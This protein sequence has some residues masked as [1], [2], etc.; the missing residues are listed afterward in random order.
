MLN[1][2]CISEIPSL[3]TF[4][5]CTVHSKQDNIETPDPAGGLARLFVLLGILLES[6]TTG[7]KCPTNKLAL[8]R[9]QSKVEDSRE[10]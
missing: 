5:P 8:T 9:L 10:K 2:G 4:I 3:P 7:K 6:F 1:V